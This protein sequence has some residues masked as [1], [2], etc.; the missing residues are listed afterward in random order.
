MTAKI[1]D[2]RAIAQEIKQEV[3]IKIAKRL[4]DG[5]PRLGLAV[6]L[7]GDDQA[8]GIYVRNK[9]LACEAVGIHS[10][11]YELPAST[12]QEK[13]LQL[14]DELNQDAAIHGIL[15]QLPLPA[16]IDPGLVLDRISPT[17][18][19][20][21]FHPYN[22]GRLVQKRPCLRPCTPYG[23]ITMLQRVGIQLKGLDA[24]IVGAS[25]IVGRPMALELLLAGCTV[26]VS[27]RFTR[28]LK[29]HVQT[30]QLLISAIGKPG[31]IQS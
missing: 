19:V 21:G 24:V 14:I 10:Q 18:D 3:S 31:I 5:L 27:H 17:K 13:L 8:S 1:I 25:N 26:T 7:L 22:V 15:V 11:V 28:D 9:R 29:S 20:D 30:A 6:V 23:I 16:H 4:A 2:G 12:P